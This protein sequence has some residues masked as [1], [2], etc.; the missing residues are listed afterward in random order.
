MHTGITYA[1]LATGSLY[2]GPPVDNLTILLGT[3]VDTPLGSPTVYV[4]D[5]ATDEHAIA[6]LRPHVRVVYDTDHVF[7]ADAR[8]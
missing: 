4:L 2:D 8:N 1:N 6:A 3:G 7:V 5:P